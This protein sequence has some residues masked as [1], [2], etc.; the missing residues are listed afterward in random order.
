MCRIRKP[1]PASFEPFNLTRIRTFTYILCANRHHSSSSN[2]SIPIPNQI[3]S[4]IEWK[5]FRVQSIWMLTQCKPNNQ[6]QLK[7]PKQ[8]ISCRFVLDLMS[9]FAFMYFI[10]VCCFALAIETIITNKSTTRESWTVLNLF[11]FFFWTFYCV[12]CSPS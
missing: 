8:Y 9:V 11:V 5:T 10:L 6:S 2:S 7:S 3:Q 1:E 4:F 12:H